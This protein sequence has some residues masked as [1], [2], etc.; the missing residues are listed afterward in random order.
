MATYS[1]TCDQGHAAEKFTVEAEN[2]EEAVEKMMKATASHGAEKHLET[3][4]MSEKEAK[5]WTKR[6]LTKE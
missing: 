4:D 5:E 3:K 2:E 1:L 6:Q